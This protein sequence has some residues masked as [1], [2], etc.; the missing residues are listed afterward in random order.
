MSE[1]VRAALAA[2]RA[3]ASAARLSPVKTEAPDFIQSFGSP[4]KQHAQQQ[5]GLS[6]SE[7]SEQAIDFVS[8]S[9][10]SEDELLLKSCQTGRLN[11]S[12]RTPAL[13]E[14]PAA[15]FSLLDAEAPEWYEEQQDELDRRPWYE[16]EDLRVLSIANAE[17]IAVDPRIGDFRA[18]AR[19]ELHNNSISALPSTA[20]QLV[21]LTSLNISKNGLQRFPDALLALDSLIDLD[22]SH[23]RLESLWAPSD[24]IKA[25][26]DRKQWDLDN[27][28]EEDGVWAGLIAR[29]GSPTKRS[30]PAPPKDAQRS[31]PMRSLRILNLA[32]NRL[33]NA[34]FGLA[35]TEKSDVPMIT[36]PPSLVELDVSDNILRGPLPLSFA[37]RLRDLTRLS[38]GGNG[39]GDEVFR[40]DAQ[41]ET[42]S[43]PFS[44]SLFPKLTFLDLTRC[45]IDDLSQIEAT[46]GSGPTVLDQ[47]ADEADTSL[48]EANGKAVLG[49]LARRLVRVTV[50]GSPTKRSGHDTQDRS[51]S[52]VL[53]G[54]P[55][56][57]ET[58]KRKKGPRGQ[59]DHAAR[60]SG[61]A[62][63]SHE[64]DRGKSS[65]TFADTSVP[66]RASPS[67]P[68][69]APASATSSKAIVKESWE[70]QAEAG[71]L[72]EG[73]RRRARA[74]AARRER[75]EASNGGTSASK[76]DA[77]RDSVTGTLSSPVR[78]G[79]ERQPQQGEQIGSASAQLLQVGGAASD[80]GSTLAN[81]KLTK[82]QSEA[83]G[84]V[85]CKFFRS[86]NGCSAGE[87][88]PFAHIAP[89]EGNGPG[90]AKTVCEFFLKGNCRFGHKCALAHLR[91]GEPMSMDRKNKKAAQQ[92]GRGGRSIETQP[93][94]VPAIQT[95]QRQ[96]Q[97]QQGAYPQQIQ[98]QQQNQWNRNAYSTH[99][100]DW[101]TAP[102]H[103]R[104][105]F[106]FG[107]PDDLAGPPPTS[108]TSG[109]GRSLH[110][111]PDPL[112]TPVAGGSNDMFIGSP[113]TSAAFGSSPFGQ[114]VFYSTSQEDAEGGAG[115]FMRRGSHRDGSFGSSRLRPSMASVGQA[116]QS[117]GI[118]EEVLVEGDEDE[119]NEEDFLPSSLSDLLT[120][121][122]LQRRR[123]SV[124]SGVSGMQKTADSMAT[125]SMPAEAGEGSAGLRSALCSLSGG[126]T[127]LAPPKEKPWS[128]YVLDE[129]GDYSRRPYGG[130]GSR[131]AIGTPAETLPSHA[132]GQSLPQGLAAGLSRLHMEA[133]QQPSADAKSTWASNGSANGNGLA[134]HRHAL[135][136]PSLLANASTGAASSASPAHSLSSSFRMLGPVGSRHVDELGPI[137]P[138]S[139][140]PHRTGGLS[141]RF[142]S[143]MSSSPLGDVQWTGSLN[144]PGAAQGSPSMLA[145]G[146]PP[147]V[148]VSGP[149]GIAI[150]SAPRAK[151][152]PGLNRATPSMPAGGS[153]LSLAPAKE[154]EEGEEGV[155]ELE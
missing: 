83:L 37:G 115:R 33:S 36:W 105:E 41:S 104:D 148:R 2:R 48:R 123:R 107:V 13:R 147:A 89:G 114:S 4:K 85:P 43:G 149:A 16:R 81:T 66:S 152:H 94:T 29:M 103:G 154:E 121:A 146:S 14:V 87:S 70:L 50:T 19:L 42:S 27:A 64:D 46:F 30:R 88:C 32:Y 60:T 102:H 120:P 126:D 31:Q 141:S 34:A 125:Q 61:P 44:Q 78:N 134:S 72:T 15:V 150:S 28:D 1:A 96:F 95:G 137:A 145:V 6:S 77:K 128:R 57:E 142:A 47:R 5:R 138:S 140:L 3:A 118:D 80:A 35:S 98:S 20:F 69:P 113:P 54:N 122:E 99:S 55:L 53:D 10:K 133:S 9:Q 49:I 76:N 58:Y 18:L 73:G 153:P 21:N 68:S 40:H 62:T 127:S 52:L 139:I 74:E 82:R 8:L 110:G 12:S 136:R 130:V 23:N 91:D 22:I 90:G 38:L 75:E 129:P 116:R 97:P 45:E 93:T 51:L 132:P 7:N 108:R 106:A 100:T 63:P 119:H 25:R 144:A 26:D 143:S 92:G 24:V 112:A 117:E 111:D 59:R 11:L 56:R 65:A 155:F 39:I 151:Q 131:H 79:V 67:K 135:N 86:A 17:L 101:S 124:L 109:I 84:R 71:L